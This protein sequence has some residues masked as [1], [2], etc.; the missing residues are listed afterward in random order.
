MGARKKRGG[1]G[2]RERGGEKERK[3]T[4]VREYSCTSGAHIRKGTTEEIVT[5]NIIPTSA[6]ELVIL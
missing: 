4:I 5:N 2:F 1:G 3:R 6:V